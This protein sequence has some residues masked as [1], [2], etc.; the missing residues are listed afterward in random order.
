MA[1]RLVALV[2]M[3]VA[4]FRDALPTLVMRFRGMSRMKPMLIAFWMLM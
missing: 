3:M 1:A 4:P 2:S